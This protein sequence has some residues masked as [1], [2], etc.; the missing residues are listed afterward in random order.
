MV[1]MGIDVTAFIGLGANEGR[2]RQSLTQAVSVLGALPGTSVESVSRLYR[3]RPVGPVAQADFLNAVV[4]MRVP[5][6]PSPEDGAM[7]L[8]VALKDIERAMGRVQR[9]HWGPREVDLDLLLFGDHRVRAVRAAAARSDDPARDGAQ[10]LV[11]PHPMA[12]ERLF[13]L[14][15]MADLAPTLQPPGWGISVEQAR[16]HALKA[17]GPDAVVAVATWDAAQQRWVTD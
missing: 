2:P 1:G 15:P 14:E 8:L 5:E 7:A 3:T 16:D 13:V 11:V 4:A 10:W 9:E 17:D 6:G 12:M